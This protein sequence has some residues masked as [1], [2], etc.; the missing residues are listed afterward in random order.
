MILKCIVEKQD[1][2]IW[3][4]LIW[5][6]IG[7]VECSCEHDN[8]LSDSINFGCATGGF[9]RRTQLHGAS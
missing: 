2:M 9:S 1:G 3:T 5:L 4:G 8:K 6:R 7:E